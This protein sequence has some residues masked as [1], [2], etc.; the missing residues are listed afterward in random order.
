MN[1]VKTKLDC[2][3]LTFPYEKH[4]ETKEQILQ[5]ISEQP[6]LVYGG[7]NQILNLDWEIRKD[8]N[9][10]WVQ[11]FRPNFELALNQAAQLN[12]YPNVLINELWFQQYKKGNEHGW[13]A[14]GHNFTGVYYL[15]FPEDA[16]TTELI[17]P[18]LTVLDNL[19]KV[20]ENEL[21]VPDV[22]EGDILIFPSFVVHRAPVVEKDINKSIVSFNIDFEF[23][24]K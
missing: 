7:G 14:H 22:N 5:L 6:P 11:L 9:R 8:W 24:S 20:D 3:Y 23:G 4:L 15:D 16:P 18:Y 10:P 21:I 19:S 13:H 17:N 2:F 1:V 12:G